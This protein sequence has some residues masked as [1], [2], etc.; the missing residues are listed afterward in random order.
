MKEIVILCV[1]YNN[2][3]E[4]VNYVEHLSE[5]TL[6]SRIDIVVVD[7]S[8]DYEEYK[9]LSSVQLSYSNVRVLNSDENLGYFR[10]VNYGLTEYLRDNEMPNWVIIS[11]TDIKF[12]DNEFLQRVINLYPKG[13]EGIIAPSIFSTYL[14]K[15][16]N[17]YATDRFSKRKLEFLRFLYKSTLLTFLANKLLNIKRKLNRSNLNINPQENREIYAPHG[18][19]MIINRNYFE[20][21]GN[22]DYKSFLFC[23]EIF[24][25]EITRKIGTK[26]FYD[27]RLKVYHNEHSTISL[28]RKKHLLKFSYDSVD[29]C[30]KEFY[31]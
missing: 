27:N 5:Q 1:N 30:L 10:G 13:I 23:E 6:F 2:S 4:V 16:Q 20:K 22:L 14:E 17:P 12:E 31:K 28:L 9:T 15:D 25:G 8:T 3:K 18:A 7:N 21:G 11:N 19:F 24:I 29:Y 26:V